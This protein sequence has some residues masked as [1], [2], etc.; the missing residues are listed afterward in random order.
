MSGANELVT[1]LLEDPF[2]SNEQKQTL[3][4][5]WK[6][7]P[8]GSRSVRIQYGTSPSADGDVVHVQSSWL[9]NF[10]LPVEVTEFKSP[11]IGVL[12]DPEIAKALFTADVPIVLCNPIS[13]PVATAATYPG[14][15][16]SREHT[17][18]AV[19][20][21]SPAHPATAAHNSQV[22]GLASQGNVRVVF[23]DPARALHGLGMLDGGVASPIS[24]QRYQDDVSGSN[25][26]S[27]THTVKELLPQGS[28]NV[29]LAARVTAVHAQTGRALIKDALATSRAVLRKAELEADAVLT[30]TSA[31][32]SQ[33]EEAK[34]K[35]HLEV[36]G[37]EGKDGDEIAKA[38][39]Q[40]KKSVQPTMDSLQ[41]YKLFW[42]VDDVREVIIAAVDR[43][44][45]RDLERK[46]V[47]HA[48]RLAALQTSFT[49]AANSLCRSFP[50]ASAY[51]SPVLHNSLA[52]IASAPS[53]P[54]TAT[55]LTGPLHTR[56]S[57]L[58]FPTE[59][60]HA[61]AQRA[62]VGMSGSVLGGFGVAWAGWATELQLFGGLIDI[63][64]SPETALGVGMLGA[65]V[66]VRWAVGRW[67]KA[68]RRW[69][70]NWDRIG[71]GLERDLKATLTQ[72]MHGH[73][74]VV[75]EAACSGLD[76]LVGK[77]RAEVEE[78]QD[79]VQTLEAELSRR[80]VEVTP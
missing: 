14:L 64:M 39:A 42:R 61:S 1:A 74:L 44:W 58:R 55:V 3:R 32:R 71:E 68:K 27:I 56:Q 37:V 65:A 21:P 63:G 8:E 52:R 10:G 73:V 22:E 30:A 16:L 66:G 5:R 59:R 15:P 13:T 17:I 77:R 76:G 11:S 45:C 51:H 46:L 24:V 62:V 31:L 6:S 50:P 38:V 19:L 78:L 40:A 25:I 48:G 41:W 75:S 67:E 23:V 2:V 47:F 49:E 7:Q 57:Q 72:T 35:V 12:P 9:Q 43:A 28:P 18:L 54:I 79:E 26:S 33:M 70:K 36:F 60:L 80:Q 34:A 69:W 20:S 4:S 29:P 53:Y